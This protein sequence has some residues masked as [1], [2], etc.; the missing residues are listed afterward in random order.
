M[1]HTAFS[2]SRKRTLA[3]DFASWT[4]NLPLLERPRNGRRQSLGLQSL[5][6]S[7]CREA[8]S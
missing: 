3:L 1:P 4:C 2:L 7:S 6:H 5:E 8:N